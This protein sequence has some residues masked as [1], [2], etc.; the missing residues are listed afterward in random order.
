MPILKGTSQKVRSLNIKELIK[1]KPGKDRA[2]GIRTLMKRRNLSFRKA[3]QLQ[4]KAIAFS[5]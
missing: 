2:K 4:A 1:T 5:Q 3:K